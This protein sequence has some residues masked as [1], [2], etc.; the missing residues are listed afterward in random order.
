MSLEQLDCTEPTRMKFFVS[1]K[2]GFGMCYCFSEN[3]VFW[4][5]WFI[6]PSSARPCVFLDLGG[7]ENIARFFKKTLQF[8]ASSR[9][10]SGILSSF[11]GAFL[12]TLKNKY[13]DIRLSPSGVFTEDLLG[14]QFAGHWQINIRFG[15][16]AHWLASKKCSFLI[17]VEVKD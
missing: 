17:F 16:T 6:S 1:R 11:Y 10:K 13:G 9:N 14:K 8:Y 7:R 12:F 4:V 3:V 2:I 15:F 5:S